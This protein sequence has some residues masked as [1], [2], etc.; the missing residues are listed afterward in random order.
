MVAGQFVEL[1]VD[2]AIWSTVIAGAGVVLEVAD[3]LRS[4][5]R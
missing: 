3:W 4:R 1:L 2:I 5:A